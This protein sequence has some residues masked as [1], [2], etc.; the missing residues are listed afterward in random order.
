MLI[1]LH[2]LSQ[3]HNSHRLDNDTYR[4]AF[5]HRL[6]LTS[7]LPTS[8][9][10]TKCSCGKDLDPECSSAMLDPSTLPLGPVEHKPLDLLNVIG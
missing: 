6:R 9:I 7:T 3:Q 8:L 10:N 1:A 4:F 5:L 2:S